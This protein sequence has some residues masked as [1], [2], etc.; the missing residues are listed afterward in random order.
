L[1]A[2]A[3]EHRIR[4]RQDASNANRDIARNLVRHELLPYLRDRFQPALDATVTRLQVILGAESGFIER[5]AGAAGRS[6]TPFDSWD[7]ALQRRWVSAQCVQ[8]DVLPDFAMVEWLRLHPGQQW[9]VDPQRV[10]W[11]EN[12]TGTVHSERVTKPEFNP[13]CLEASLLGRTGA[14]QFDGMSVTWTATPWRGWPKTGRRGPAGLE[15]FD[16]DKV[17]TSIRL[18]HWRPGDRFQPIGMARPQKVQDLFTNLKVPPVVRRQLVLAESEA[19]AG[20]IF[21]IEGM[22]ISERFKIDPQTVR[23]LEWQWVREVKLDGAVPPLV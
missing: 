9:M 10:V 23:C 2:F 7:T 19:G 13:K 3:A 18:R 22:R 12:L 4:F 5:A 14:I 6:G 17:G 11:R 16:R 20:G 15:R 1:Q 21:W 8:L